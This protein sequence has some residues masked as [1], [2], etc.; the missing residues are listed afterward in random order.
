PG[1]QEEHRCRAAGP[2]EAAEDAEA[3]LPRQPP[4]EH[5][6]VPRAGPQR[7]PGLLPVAG[8]L[9]GEAL[10]AQ[11]AHDEVGQLWLVLADQDADAH[12]PTRPG[13]GAGGPPRGWD[14]RARQPFSFSDS[15]FSSVFRIFPWPSTS[16]STDFLSPVVRWNS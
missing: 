12:G 9:D 7:L 8:V 2:A 14:A 11:A 3:V 4:V 15:Y 1:R 16:T 6:E 10:L 13:P 5:D